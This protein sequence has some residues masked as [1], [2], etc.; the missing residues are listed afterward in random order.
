MRSSSC[1]AS[2]ANLPRLGEVKLD[3]TAFAFAVSVAIVSSVLFGLAPAWQAARVE[4][5]EGLKRGGARGVVGRGPHGLRDAVVVAEIALSLVLAIGAGLLFRSF[6][7]LTAVEMGFRSE[8]LLVM[9]AHAPAH[10][11]DEHLR[12]GRSYA[13]LLRQVRGIPGVR[14]AAAAMG[15]PAGHYGSNG[16]FAVEGKHVFGS[17]QR[18]PQAGFRLASPTYFATMGIPLVAG[19]DFTAQDVYESPFVAVVSAS[20]ASQALP[21]ENPL[22][23]RIQLGL[24]SPSKWVTIVGVVA[25]VRFASQAAPPGPEIYM[26]LRQHP[27]FANEVEVAVRT[28]VPP[29]P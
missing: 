4:V 19:R 2:P 14:S 17:G 6:L 9:Y 20:L 23:R 10:G 7:L 28:G 3:L 1:S 13:D 27:F 16:S 8:G 18:L 25:D 11:L 21:G 12:V 29:D 26:P 22:G 15:L 5:G 24:D